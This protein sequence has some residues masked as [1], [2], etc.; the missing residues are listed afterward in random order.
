MTN[1]IGALG[2]LSISLEDKEKWYL[3]IAYRTARVLQAVEHLVMRFLQVDPIYPW[4][5]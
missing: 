2:D 4:R 3:K 5:Q 1:K